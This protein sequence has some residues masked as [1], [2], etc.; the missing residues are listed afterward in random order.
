M[1]GVL[2]TRAAIAAAFLLAALPG[3]GAAEGLPQS[4]SQ[5]LELFETC[6][7]RLSALIEHQWLVEPAASDRTV[8]LRAEFDAL[9]EAVMPDAVGWGMPAEMP[10]HW[11]VAAKAAQADLLATAVFSLDPQRALRA[12]RAAEERLA[13]CD[14]VLIG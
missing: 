6:A 9:V 8:S 13:E 4:P 10:M 3:P 12:R 11:R 1:C 14:G 2:T 5:R 7:G